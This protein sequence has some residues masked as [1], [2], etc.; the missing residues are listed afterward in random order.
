MSSSVV[1]S[2]EDAPFPSSSNNHRRRSIPFRPAGGLLSLWS[3]LRNCIGKELTK[4]PIPVQFNEPLSVTQRITEDLEY[5][6]LLD[7]AAEASDPYEQLAYVGAYAISCYS[8]TA[9]RTTKP[10]NPLLGETYECDRM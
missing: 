5:A 3:I 4:I 10:F 7:R 6:Y 2:K 8:T 1:A 9:N